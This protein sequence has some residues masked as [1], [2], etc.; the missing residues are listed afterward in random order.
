M[1]S[2]MLRM[3]KM[4]EAEDI[5]GTVLIVQALNWKKCH[6]STW[7]ISLKVGKGLSHPFSRTDKQVVTI[8]MMFK[9]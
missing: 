8:R 3:K 2:E 9:K 7:K 1:P 6:Y 4:R 5:L